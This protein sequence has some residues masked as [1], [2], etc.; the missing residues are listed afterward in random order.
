MVSEVS[1]AEN[2]T[3]PFTNKSISIRLD[4]TNYLLW[5][6]QIIFAIESLALTDHIDSDFSVPDQHILANGVRSVN[7]EFTR[8]KQEDS[9]L[10]SWL[11]SSMGPS[12]LPALV[13]YK[14][15]LQIWE[16]VR[17]I[18]SVTSTTRVMH[19]HCSLKNIRKRDQSM[20]D[21]AQIQSVCDSLAACGNPLSETMHISTIL[22][23]LPSEYEPVV[24]VITSSQQPYK[25]DGVTS[26]L[27]DTESRQLEVLAQDSLANLVQG[28]NSSMGHNPFN[29]S[30]GYLASGPTNTGYS[31]A[32]YSANSGYGYS[33]TQRSSVPLFRPNNPNSNSARGGTPFRGRGGRF[34]PGR[35]RP[36]CQICGKIGHLA[37]RCYFRFDQA[38]EGIGNPMAVNQITY[39]DDDQSFI[40]GGCASLPSQDQ[41]QGFSGQP[42]SASDPV[43]AS[44]AAVT[45]DFS[46]GDAA[47]YPD[48]GATSH[49]TADAGKFLSSTPYRGSGKV[50][51]ADGSSIP[52]SGIGNSVINSCL[53]PL[54][55]NNLLHVLVVSK[56]LLSVSK[57][58]KDNNVS[59]EF[60]PNF[61]VVKDLIT[62][63]VMLR[64]SQ[65]DGLYKIESS[66]IDAADCAL[67]VNNCHKS[68][69][70][71]G[72]CSNSFVPCNLSSGSNVLSS[73]SCF[74]AVDVNVWH[75]RL[76]HPSADVMSKLST[77][78]NFEK[79]N[80][81]LISCEACKLGKSHKLPF[82]SSKTV[83]D[84][85]LQNVQVDVWGSAPLISNNFCYYVSFVDAATRYTWIY[86]AAKK[87]DVAKLVINFHTMAE[88]QSDCKL[89][90]IQS[91]CGSEFK[92]LSSYF[93]KHGIQFLNTC[94]YTSEQIGRVERKHRHIVELGLTL[95]AQSGVPFKFW[96]DSFYTAV[97]LINRLPSKT[98]GGCS[99]YEKMFKKEPNYN[100]MRIFGCQCYPLTRPYNQ[101][102]LQFRSKP[103]LFLGYS[104]TQHGYKCLDAEGKLIVSRHV[105]FNEGCFP[106]LQDKGVSTSS[107]ANPVG[108]KYV[109]P[110]TIVSPQQ[111]LYV[112]TNSSRSS[113]TLFSE[114]MSD[115]SSVSVPSSQQ[116]HPPVISS[117]R[118]APSQQIP[119]VVS[120]P[121]QASS[122]QIP[123]SQQIPQQASP[124]FPEFVS[125]LVH[126]HNSEYS[127]SVHPST[128][129]EPHVSELPEHVSELP[130]SV[131]NSANSP[132]GEMPSGSAKLPTHTMVTRSKAGVFKPKV[133]LAQPDVQDSVP[134]TI[135][136]AMDS[137]VWKEAVLK[138]YEALLSK[139]TW[140]LV[141]LPA[142]RIPIGCK[143]LFKIK[144]NSDGSIARYKARLVAKGFSQQAGFDYFETYS[145]VVKL[146]TVRILLSVALNN[147]WCLR[148]IDIDNAFLNGDLSEEV[149]M[150]Q[151]P[152]FEQQSSHGNKLVCKLQKSLYGLK[153]APRAWFEKFRNHLVTSLK[154]T[155]SLADSSLYF[156]E[157]NGNIVYIMVY[158]DDIVVTGNSATE[159]SL[160][161]EDISK[162]FSLKDLGQ[163]TYFLGMNIQSVSQGL[164]LS[165][166]KHILELL[167]KTK[168]NDATVTPTP[169]VTS[170]QISSKDG[171]A[172]EDG[173]LYRQ[174]VG[175]LQHICTTRLDIQFAVNKLSQYM[176]APLDKHWT[177]V[178][179]IIRYLKVTLNHGLFFSNSPGSN[180]LVAYTDSDWGTSI[181]DKR[182]TGGHCVFLGGNLV[183][184]GSKKQSV[185]SRSSTEAEFRS[186]A[187]TMCDTMWVRSLLSELKIQLSK[188][189]VIWCDNTSA[190]AHSANPVHHAKLKHVEL[191]LS[192]VREKVA[193]GQ[194]QVCYVPASEQIADVL[195]KPL[196]AAFF[197]HLRQKL[198]VYYPDELRSQV[199]Q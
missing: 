153:Q 36:Q 136:Q 163:L 156:R 176:Q 41:N 27:L 50:C 166:K 100:F 48:S 157:S 10:C 87:Y 146:V 113:D 194:F 86:F 54:Q 115:D 174:V 101:N 43:I 124:S 162:A 198:R 102:K 199:T 33:N 122:Q 94:P 47:W 152:G 31:N 12:I 8:F 105:Q 103:C 78:C 135:Q 125:E 131:S 19:L 49:L 51:V 132:S 160:V 35:S 52:I 28:S 197:V 142:D 112:P 168:M 107:M 144:H 20:R 181:D 42:A 188:T 63:Q 11:L 143:W 73:T 83:Y 75:R 175:T 111:E 17:Q 155:S 118:Q 55:L 60:F 84:K 88:R 26:V 64:G 58:T 195:T 89:K 68:F 66:A 57:F 98:L 71:S 67:F 3:K 191:D 161:I 172:L 23:G 117:P 25:L 110:R 173:S 167:E 159:V 4:D 15:A 82:H 182:S 120:S 129:A 133:F 186:L 99:P 29:S 137:P 30:F 145:P 178:K 151:P 74:S 2:S 170:P 56:N 171:V 119:P 180:T 93:A 149:Y 134:T 187:D 40:Q 90:V 18:F 141:D 72:Q 22:S 24:A 189:H 69:L 62:R 130:E 32:G 123:F 127:S 164:I 7:P 9:A 79:F 154:F 16:K 192:F 184:W 109:K 138:E 97:Y 190:I 6:Q 14:N 183:S 70:D 92:P 158:V 177:A 21:L 76:G 81:D 126:E 34:F 38:Y 1:M 185:V 95:M 193:A 46:F 121:L 150:Q 106:C 5:K 77:L 169:M 61:C 39:S 148:Q 147:G 114:P 196:S 96:S 65:N 91:D 85:P 140:T 37:N 59:V 139:E 165:Q 128:V 53:R 179:R 44:V 116:F 108:S 80:K 45:E 104:S 13:N